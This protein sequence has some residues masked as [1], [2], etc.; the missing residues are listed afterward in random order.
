M[1]QPAQGGGQQQPQQQQTNGQQA[2]GQQQGQG[3]QGTTQ[4][5]GGTSGLTG[6][7]DEQAG[8]PQ[9][10]GG[11][12]GEQQQGG[13]G[14]TGTGPQQQTAQPATADEIARIVESTVDR[15]INAVLREVRGQGGSGQQ[16]QQQGGQQGQSAEQGGGQQ[17]Q[18]SGQAAPA[19]PTAADL[20]EA[21]LVYREY[22][23]DE[24]Q[25]LGTVEREHASTLAG[26]LIQERLQ[27]GDDHETAGREAAKT[28]A[29]TVKNLRQ[30]YE[31]QT[32]AALQ[33]RGL[34][35]KDGRGPGQQPVPGPQAPGDQSSFAA[36]ATKAATMFADRMPQP[37]AGAQ[38]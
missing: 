35:P 26:A 12:Q 2:G 8:Q 19:G 4:E 34:L 30:H 7:L 36:G 24:V 3:Q 33:R 22:V 14:Q 15:R 20:R 13:T 29:S 25:F 9:G 1:T 16:G 6:L 17:Q 11:Q 38:Q 23:Q 28:V 18:T 31:Q 27:R 32:I 5:Q 10:D 21:R 37:A